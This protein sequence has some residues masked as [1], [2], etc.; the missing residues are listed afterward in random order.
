M[1]SQQELKGQMSTK[2]LEQAARKA[3]FA[4]AQACSRV[5]LVHELVLFPQDGRILAGPAEHQ[6]DG[7]QNSQGPAAAQSNQQG[8]Q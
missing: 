7:H 5:Q 6:L 8:S 2:K 1:Q 4:G 3:Q